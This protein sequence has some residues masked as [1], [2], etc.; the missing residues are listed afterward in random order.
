MDSR[1]TQEDKVLFSWNSKP[2]TNTKL[3]QSLGLKQVEGKF[4]A[5]LGLDWDSSLN[6]QPSIQIYM[7]L[8]LSRSTY[9][10]RSI[11]SIFVEK[12]YT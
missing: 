11:L 9:I 1:L 2:I 12:K 8:E 4:K 3:T 5:S 6:C 10:L 7:K